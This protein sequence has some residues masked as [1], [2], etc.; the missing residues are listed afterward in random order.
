MTLHTRRALA[1]RCV[2]FS[3]LALTVG[4]A[5]RARGQEVGTPQF[6]V[7][8]LAFVYAQCG[9]AYMAQQIADSNLNIT[10]IHL[11]REFE[12][13]PQYQQALQ[14]VTNAREALDAAE[15]PILKLLAGDAHYQ[16]LAAKRLKMQ[17]VLSE[18]GLEFRDLL[19]IAW[20]KMQYGSEMHRMEGDALASDPSV[21]EAR[22]Q[23][24]AAQR[25]A[26]LMR[27]RFEA[28]LYRNPQWMAARQNYDSAR[29]ALAG[30]QAAVCGVN[31]TACLEDDAD[32]RH[33][34]YGDYSIPF[35]GPYIAAAY[36][37][38]RY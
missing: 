25:T 19:D 32:A 11:Q 28:T 23:L 34:I 14:D 37:G 10:A 35:T 1:H 24:V 8:S 30:A 18:D 31:T 5:G 12:L 26:D 17:I 36:Y 6:G 7:E 22:K 29:I 2:A 21:Q 4:F 3:I 9:S 15:R 38:R 33:A 27:K 16:E 20:A 13:S